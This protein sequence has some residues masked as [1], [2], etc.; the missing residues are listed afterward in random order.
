MICLFSFDKTVKILLSQFQTVGGWVRHEASA[1][2][3]EAIV[4]N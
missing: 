3:K 1:T 2:D 4:K